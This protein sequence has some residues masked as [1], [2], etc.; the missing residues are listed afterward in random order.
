[1]PQITNRGL[2]PNVF[3]HQLESNLSK[4]EDQEFASG[5][6][7]I[8]NDAEMSKSINVTGK[9]FDSL[10]S[11]DYLEEQ[12]K[13]RKTEMKKISINKKTINKKEAKKKD[14]KGKDRKKKEVKKKEKN[15]KEISKKTLNTIEVKKAIGKKET[16]NGIISEY[17]AT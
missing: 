3:K 15:A 13:I 14:L 7:I 4:K 10:E 16:I 5:K 9:M 6:K 12:P 2:E 1:M 8:E 11:H 17:F